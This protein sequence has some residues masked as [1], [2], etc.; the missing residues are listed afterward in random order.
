MTALRSCEEGKPY[1]PSGSSEEDSPQQ[2]SKMKELSTCV[3]N[4]RGCSRSFVAHALLPFVTIAGYPDMT[5]IKGW[6]ISELSRPK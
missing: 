5:S 1:L 4:R 2:L 3:Q 6:D